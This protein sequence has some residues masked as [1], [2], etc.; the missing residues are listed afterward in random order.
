MNFIKLNSS[1][2]PELNIG[3]CPLFFI[4]A[5]HIFVPVNLWLAGEGTN[6]LTSACG[7]GGA[8]FQVCSGC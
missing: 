4:P 6:S 2:V 1:Q 5:A 8:L 7:S 3:K